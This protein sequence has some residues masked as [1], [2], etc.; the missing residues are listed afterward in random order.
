MSKHIYTYTH[1]HKIG[2][3]DEELLNFHNLDNMNI[4][5]W[6]RAEQEWIQD[7]FPSGFRPGYVMCIYTN[8][9]IHKT[10]LNSVRKTVRCNNSALS[11]NN[12]Y[13]DSLIKILNNL[14]RITCYCSQMRSLGS[15]AWIR[16]ATTKRPRELYQTLWL[17]LLE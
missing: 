11:F 1:T 6:G 10:P 12:N 13:S 2:V 15:E 3:H 9:H 5:T 14:K 8:T 4:W 16:K 17:F 7:P